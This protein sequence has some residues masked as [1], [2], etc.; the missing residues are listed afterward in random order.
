M[1]FRFIDNHN[2]HT[3]EGDDENDIEHDKEH[4][5][6]AIYKEQKED[7]KNTTITVT[8]LKT[9][10]IEPVHTFNYSTPVASVPQNMVFNHDLYQYNTKPNLY[11]KQKNRLHYGGG[12]RR[13]KRF[14]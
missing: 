13:R 10:P 14:V 11:K 7:V 4:D 3:N 12:L 6:N 2:T 9:D 5:Q 1:H 8:K